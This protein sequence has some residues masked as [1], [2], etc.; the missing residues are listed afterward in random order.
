MASVDKSNSIYMVLLLFLLLISTIVTGSLYLDMRHK[1]SLLEARIDQLEKSQVLLM[2]PDA[3]AQALADWMAKNPEVTQSL[4]KQAKPGV[5]TSVEI[6]PGVDSD[7]PTLESDT[8]EN[9]R[10]A[11]NG[12]ISS[13]TSEA[14]QDVSDVVIPMRAS[15]GDDMANNAQTVLS[16]SAADGVKIDELSKIE[17]IKLSEDKDG[18]KVISLPHGGIRVTTREDN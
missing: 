7:E 14:K 1:N 10:V 2:V 8:G 13:A 6:G 15:V 18:V 12:D 11:T 9:L 3:Q 5:R 17:L 4:I 16:E